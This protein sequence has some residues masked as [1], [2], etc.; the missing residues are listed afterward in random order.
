MI[1]DDQISIK[2]FEDFAGSAVRSIAMGNA[3]INAQKV[4]EI[5]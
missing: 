3:Q 1:G 4:A 5:V 2:A